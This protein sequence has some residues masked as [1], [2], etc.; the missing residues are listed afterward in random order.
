MHKRYTMP[1]LARKCVVTVT[2]DVTAHRNQLPHRSLR[3]KN[4]CTMEIM[5]A[6][7]AWWTF[8]QRGGNCTMK[9]ML[10]PRPGTQ[11]YSWAVFLIE[12]IID[13]QSLKK[14]TQLYDWAP[15]LSGSFI[16]IVQLPPRWNEYA[17]S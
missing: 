12:K 5:R 14:T 1:V 10:P 13:I 15:G 9:T 3:Q 8:V 11:S 17:P 6:V 16:S 4:K 7:L 2:V